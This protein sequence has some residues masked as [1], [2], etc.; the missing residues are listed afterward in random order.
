LRLSLGRNHVETLEVSNENASDLPGAMALDA[1][2]GSTTNLGAGVRVISRATSEA[3]VLVDGDAY[4]TSTQPVGA[5]RM[6]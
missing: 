5:A 6:T 1:R 3:S 2:H 4:T